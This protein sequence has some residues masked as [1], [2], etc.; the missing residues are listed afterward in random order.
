MNTV[1]SKSFIVAADRNDKLAVRVLKAMADETF[2]GTMFETLGSFEA[3]VGQDGNV[4]HHRLSGF[5]TLKA[6]LAVC[7]ENDLL[8]LSVNDQGYIGPCHPKGWTF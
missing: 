1:S 7:W 2:P 6:I 5:I 3:N 8:L 4:H